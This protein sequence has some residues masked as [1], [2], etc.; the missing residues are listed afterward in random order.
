MRRFFASLRM[1]GGE[2][3]RVS[4]FV[5]FPWF[6][7]SFTRFFVSYLWLSCHTYDFSCHSLDFLVIPMKMGIHLFFVIQSDFYCHS[8]VF[9]CQSLDFY[10]HLLAFSCHTYDFLVIHLF[11]C[12]S[13]DFF[14]S[15]PRK[16]ESRKQKKSGSPIKT[17][18]DDNCVEFGG[19]SL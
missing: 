8:R 1:T 4:S 14:L 2:Q 5:S 12:Y 16:R 7:L 18:G 3:R 19:D 9:Y 6:L 17:F 15:F 10:C 13:Y 11:F